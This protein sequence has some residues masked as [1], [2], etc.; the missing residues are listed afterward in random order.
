VGLGFGIAL[1]RTLADE[2]ITELR[3]PGV[4]LVIFLV[5]AGLVGVLAAVWPARRA[6]K[7]DVL[8]AIA[9]H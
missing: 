3:V 9:T 8:K 2:G 6:A 7:L 4:Q 1:Q 5:V